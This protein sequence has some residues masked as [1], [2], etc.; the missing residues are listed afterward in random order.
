MSRLEMVKALMEVE[1][2][3]ANFKNALV[4]VM[5]YYCNDVDMSLELDSGQF[6]KKR[7]YKGEMIHVNKEI[8]VAYLKLEIEKLDK[9]CLEIIKEL[10]R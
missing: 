3:K 4:D 8:F 6:P 5:D 10:S 1:E 7:K 9:Q 2:N